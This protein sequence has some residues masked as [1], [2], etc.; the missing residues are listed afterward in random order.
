M[1][2]RPQIKCLLSLLRKGTFP[3]GAQSLVLLMQLQSEEGHCIVQ[4]VYCVER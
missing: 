3:Y 4:S 2:F 1:I